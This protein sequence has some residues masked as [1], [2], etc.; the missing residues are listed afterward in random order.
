MRHGI[1]IPT[2]EKHEM[3]NF[4]N[5][6]RDEVEQQ[7]PAWAEW[8]TAADTDTESTEIIGSDSESSSS[9]DEEDEEYRPFLHLPPNPNGR[10]CRCGSTTHM[11]INSF[12]CP[13]NPRNLAAAAATTIVR[14]VLSTQYSI[15][16]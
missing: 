15:H 1:A 9:N 2:S 16:P 12:A 5:T 10:R 6:P 3:M 14:D 7:P 4:L 11:T 13:L 8:S